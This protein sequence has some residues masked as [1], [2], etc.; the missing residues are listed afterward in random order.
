MD[1]RRFLGC[2]TAVA[3]GAAGAAVGGTE[4]GTGVA[5]AAAHH[6]PVALW[7]EVGGF[8][9][10]GYL[11]LRPPSLAVYADGLLIADAARYARLGHHALGAFTSFAEWVLR[12]PANGV[13]R[14]G[15]PVIADLP[16]TRLTARR[17][18]RSWTISALGLAAS[19]S[20]EAYPRPLYALLDRFT[21][22]RDDTLHTG[23]EFRP[24]AVRLVTVRVDQPPGPTVPAWPAG[25]PVPVPRGDEVWQV[26][27]LYGA[28]ARATVRGI[29]HDDATQFTAY[30]TAGGQVLNAAWRRLLPHE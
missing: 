3:A 4:F 8:V 27:D 12:N 19:R 26:L 14:P 29:A 25:V 6:R 22:H 15:A 13:R 11:A 23:R 10:A 9:S 7:E 17:G 1:R 20:S 2:A 21:A 24:D 16:T 30:R 28:A 5:S 18:S